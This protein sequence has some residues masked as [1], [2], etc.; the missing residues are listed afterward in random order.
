MTVTERIDRVAG[1]VDMAR[2]WRGTHEKF[3]YAIDALEMSAHSAAADKAVT[4]LE[5]RWEALLITEAEKFE[6][7]LIRYLSKVRNSN[8][9]YGDD[10]A[11]SRGKRFI[12]IYGKKFATGARSAIVFVEKETGLIWK[13]ASW[14]GPALNFP[15]GS[16]FE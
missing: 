12:R 3:T 16:I 5:E 11:L 10:V 2:E 14:K 9:Y 6:V 4:A 15:R 7:A 8:D 13:A 1:N